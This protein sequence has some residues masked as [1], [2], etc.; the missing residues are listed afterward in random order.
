[1]RY[2]SILVLL[3]ILS[4]TAIG[5][6]QESPEFIKYK[7]AYPDEYLARLTSQRL[8]DISLDDDEIK[9]SQT[10]EEE[11]LLLNE[12]AQFATEE[13]VE[14]SSFFLLDKIEAASLVY[15]GKKYREYEVT[16]FVRKDELSESF[17]DDTKSVNFL[18]PK[19]QQGAIKKLNYTTSITNPRFLSPVYFGN[20]YPLI[21]QKVEIVVDKDINLRFQKFNMEGVDVRFRESEKRGRKIYTWEIENQEAY[22]LESNGPSPKTILPHIIPI[23]SSYEKK[24]EEIPV[25]N[26]VKDLYNWYYSLVKDINQEELDD[27]LVTITNDL[28]ASKTSEIDK[29]KAIYYWVQENIKY[30]DF[31]YA[32]GGF[33]P[34]DANAVFQKKFGDCKDNS[35]I[36]KEM[37]K[38]AKIK[39]SLTWLGTRSIPYSYEDV[40][41]PAA[42]NHM[43]LT[44][45][46]EG[47]TYFL[48]ATGR[49]LPLEIPSSFIQGKEALIENGEGDY[50]IVKV[51]VVPADQNIYSDVVNIKLDNNSIKGNG[52][53]T[54]TGYQKSN[55]FNYIENRDT[56]EKLLEYYNSFLRKGSNRF[57]VESFE[58]K[59]KYSYEKPFEVDYNFTIKDYAQSLNDEIFINLNLY[60]TSINAY[61]IKE[62]RKTNIE[63]KYRS[64]DS[65]TVVF[66]I[67]EGKEVTY[68]PEDVAVDNDFMS[69][70]ISYKK[71]GSKII[72]THAYKTKK[73][74]LEKETHDAFRKSLKKINKAFK[75]VVVL[76]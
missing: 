58:E 62:D 46:S 13:S 52:T 34:R 71:E 21:K 29:V 30:I 2:T 26:G 47:K 33:I 1:M 65:I 44:Y 49:Y 75:E 41:T 39:G 42:D 60:K 25:L 55:T 63:F 68:L 36:L 69:A 67:P 16:D 28:I 50:K 66:E 57:L 53:L 3:C 51:P 22:D 73:L 70:S 72:Y 15:D 6:A 5:N 45:E 4:I 18:Y 10:I 37:F 27:E 56:Q 61:K 12:T 24:N 17:Y 74:I 35:S 23:I 54:L 11:D 76:K 40:P 9:I 7:N 19:L 48:D 14:Y 31:E 43:I 8:I 59:N 38:I 64:E 32:L 20:V